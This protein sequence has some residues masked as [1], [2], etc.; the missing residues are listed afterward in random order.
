M[1]F[2]ECVTRI[3]RQMA[4][5]RGDTDAPT[6]FSD[7]QH[8]A[9]LQIAQI[10]VQ[11]ELIK[12]TAERLIPKERD[13]SGAIALVNGTRTYDLASDFVRFY[14]IAHI[15][16]TS[17]GMD[18]FPYPGGLEALQV[19]DIRY[20]T[21]SGTPIA[22][23]DEPADSTNKKVGFWPVP[24]VAKTLQYDYEQVTLVSSASDNLPFHNDEESYVF[25]D[26]A[27]R[28]F[29]YMW[30]DTKAESDIALVLEKDFSYRTAR[31]TLYQLLR[32][33]NL[34]SNYGVRYG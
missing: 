34:T 9:S 16:N 11:N 4:I 3:F 14:G 31:S 33:K 13:T 30:Q 12:L 19:A 26:M 32:G 7:T 29:K 22:F 27:G 23:Y 25:T 20:A 6:S 15:Y 17:D 18:I 10:A 24:N 5:I 28:R 2:L 8:N 21:T 1:T